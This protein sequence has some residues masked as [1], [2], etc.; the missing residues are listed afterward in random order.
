[1][2]FICPKRDDIGTLTITMTFGCETWN[3]TKI[4]EQQIKTH[5]TVWKGKGHT[6]NDN[7]QNSKTRKTKFTGISE[8]KDKKEFSETRNQ[9][10]VI[11]WM[12]TKIKGS[13]N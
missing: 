2:G 5:T 6:L 1:M 11:N 13:R 10:K 3:T 7:N 12:A 9:R 8:E 4:Q